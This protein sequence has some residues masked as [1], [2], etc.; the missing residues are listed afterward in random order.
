[1]QST[2]FRLVSAVITLLLLAGLIAVVSLV[3][4]TSQDSLTMQQ[5][6]LSAPPPVASQRV[7]DSTVSQATSTSSITSSVQAG[8][9]LLEH[10]LAAGGFTFVQPSAYDLDLTATAATLTNHTGVIFVLRGGTP[11]QLSS[12]QATDLD[13]MFDEFVAFYARQDNFQ[14]RNKQSILVQGANGRSVDLVSQ[15]SRAGFSGRIVM[16]QPTPEQLFLLVGI[17]PAQQW[18]Q[19]AH[20]AFEDLLASVTFFP[21]PTSRSVAALPVL[22]P[23]SATVALSSVASTPASGPSQTLISTDLAPTPSSPTL[24]STSLSPP[25]DLRFA[26][27]ARR[28]GETGWRTYSNSNVV[29]ALTVLNTTIWAATDG[30][31]GAWNRSNNSFVKYTTLD[32]LGVNRTTAVVNCPLPGFGLIFGSAQ[33]LQIFDPQR[34]VWKVLNSTNSEMHF[35][36]VST[37]YCNQEKGF[38]VIG[39]TEHGLDIFDGKS[40]SWTAID[41][42]RGLPQNRV[43]AV[44]V[45]GD[46]AE[47][48]VSWGAGIAVLAAN[49]VSIY[50]KSNAPLASHPVNVML[51]DAQGTVWLGA[52]DQ[53]YRIANEQW[54]IYSATYV[55]ASAFPT[56][57]ITALALVGDGTLW[58]GSATG[59]LCLFDPTAVTCQAFFTPE[60]LASQSGITGLAVDS[61]QR[62]YVATARAGVR[63]YDGKVWRTISAPDEIILSNH[64]RTF[65]QDGD[66]F[67]WLATDVGLYQINPANDRIVQFF[68]SAN[69]PYP[70][71][72]IVTLFP[73]PAGGL[74]VGGKGVGYFDGARWITYTTANGLA[75]DHIQVIAGD[76]QARI[77]FGTDQG[78]SIWNGETFFTLT[79]ADQLPSDNIL[80][81]LAD[82]ETM[83]IGSDAGL[84]RYIG[85]QFQIYTT[86]TTA[87]AGNRIAVLTSVADGALLIGT[88]NGLSRW[89]ANEMS[90]IEETRG[91]AVT[92]IALAQDDTVWLG[93]SDQGVLYFDGQKWTTPPHAVNPPAPAI[94]ALAVDLQGSLWLAGLEGGMIRYDP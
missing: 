57:A 15:T 2:S 89:V 5:P 53:V 83:W 91:Y 66:G 42:R 26:A 20:K 75:S 34:D 33:G 47:I 73:A 13:R 80:S 92:A 86:A 27:S 87:L 21:L 71:E 16:A 72:E 52:G 59:E 18:A 49:K 41:Q 82:A 39:Y 46:R 31:V 37:L 9:H 43:E 54:T 58:I 67:L 11:A 77:W 45:V 60:A 48:W 32:G 90:I 76:A 61:L 8:S 10:R 68:T 23:V 38:L 6:S 14:G 79:R 36:D 88:D 29:N 44:T 55:L 64:V 65:A 63:L 3:M 51:S 25:P 4:H 85:K 28:K 40:E 78:L 94:R 17:S 69:T 24:R 7:I 56:G 1:M 84:L 93:T 74:W 22:P 81:L 30:G 19:T 50:D 70:V 35:D 12:V 62:V